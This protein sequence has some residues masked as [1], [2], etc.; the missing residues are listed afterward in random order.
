MF[1]VM[2]TKNLVVNIK[3]TA[4]FFSKH[5][6]TNLKK[7]KIILL[8]LLPENELIE[9]ENYLASLCKDS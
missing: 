6:V 1:T 4:R 8:T 7:K 5:F 3:V 2:P 9:I